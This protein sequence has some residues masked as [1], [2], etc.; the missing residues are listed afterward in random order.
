[1]K[2]SLLH[3]FLLCPS[4]FTTLYSIII[5]FETYSV[6]MNFVLTQY[7]VKL[8][9]WITNQFNEEKRNSS[10]QTGRF[11]IPTTCARIKLGR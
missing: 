9:H 2:L 5:L 7:S 10:E 8:K 1:M 3:L 4:Y 6:I 11:M